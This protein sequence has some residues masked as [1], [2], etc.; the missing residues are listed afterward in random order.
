MYCAI[1]P[2]RWCWVT[3]GGSRPLTLWWAVRSAWYLPPHCCRA[4]PAPLA[5]PSA[6]CS[7]ACGELPSLVQGSFRRIHSAG[8]RLG[9]HPWKNR[10][11]L[12]TCMHCARWLPSPVWPSGT[13]SSAG[14]SRQGGWAVYSAVSGVCFVVLFT[15]S[16]AGTGQEG[17]LGEVAGLLQRIAVTIGL[18]WLTLL[19]GHLMRGSA[20][21]SREG[22]SLHR[23]V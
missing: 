8:T 16:L 13:L 20:K 19:A 14:D 5:P 4:C 7:S 17:G 9:L 6:L 22:G 18:T 21:V 10:P 23:S 12:E 15:L 11:S 3:W 1:P 2:V